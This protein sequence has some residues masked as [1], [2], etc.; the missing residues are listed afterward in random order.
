M[1]AALHPKSSWGANENDKC[2][3]Q[4]SPEAPQLRVWSVDQQHPSP[5]SL[6]E[7]SPD[8]PGVRHKAP[9]R[10]VHEAIKVDHPTWTFPDP[11]LTLR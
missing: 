1:S 7:V 6:L 2:S 5:G 3:E 11:D 4:K 8:L 9:S 10:G